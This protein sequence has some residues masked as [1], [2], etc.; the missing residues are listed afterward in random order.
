[1]NY[2]FN[3][4]VMPT[5]YE[6]CHQKK[7]KTPHN[8][9]HFHTGTD[10]AQTFTAI[11]DILISFK[12]Q[13]VGKVGLLDSLVIPFQQKFGIPLDSSKIFQLLLYVYKELM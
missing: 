4:F 13:N 1:M 7:K 9:L 2:F 11:L 3:V 8:C 10:E 5:S 12:I 6:R